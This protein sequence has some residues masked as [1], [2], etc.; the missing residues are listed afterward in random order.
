MPDLRGLSLRKSLR[1]LK[2][3]SVEIR[4]YGTGRVVA[5]TPAAG[6]PLTDV[7]ECILTLQLKVNKDRPGKEV[8]RIV[9]KSETG[10]GNETRK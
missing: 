10:K 6:T 9:K 4:V 8:S 1:L 7:K 3:T 2:G 5:Q